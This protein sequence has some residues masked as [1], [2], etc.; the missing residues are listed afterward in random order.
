M[1]ERFRTH[2]IA[3][4]ARHVAGFVL[5]A[6]ASVAFGGG[7]SG[8]A[9]GPSPEPVHFELVTKSALPPAQQSPVGSLG[10]QI[11]AD[12]QSW[13]RYGAQAFADSVPS[14]RFDDEFVLCVYQG[15]KPT[16]GYEITIRTLEIDA[17]TLR[18]QLEL[19]EPEPGA[20]LIQ[21]VTNPYAIY[22]VQLPEAARA[23]TKPLDLELQFVQRRDGSESKLQ[24]QR[25]DRP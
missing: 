11:I 23:K 25:L 5:A 8:C 22:R 16:G 14:I 24:V 10:Y 12:A 15:E 6:G 2:R 9:T 4:R 20:M 21:V 18:V 19:H 1:L 7:T 3:P 13:S 17:A